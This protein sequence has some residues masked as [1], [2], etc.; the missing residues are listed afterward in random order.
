MKDIIFV[1]SDFKA[2]TNILRGKKISECL[3]NMGV[4]C[5]C[6]TSIPKNVNNSILIFIG[7]FTGRYSISLDGLQKLKSNNNKIIL[8]V[9]DKL[10]YLNLY[11]EKE[12]PY[13]Y[14]LDGIIFPN[15]FSENHFMQDLSCKSTTIYHQYDS[16]LT[17]FPI[18]KSQDF[19]VCYVGVVYQD[20]YFMN[21]PDWLNITNIEI[22]PDI[23]N[24]FKILKEYPIHFSHRSPQ[25]Q[26][27]YFK[28]S[29]KISIAAATNSVFVTSKDKTVVELLGENY[30]LYINED[31]D[32]TNKLINHLKLEFV[33]SNLDSYIE[34]L[35]PIKEKLSIN[36]ICKEYI[37]FFKQL[38]Q[39]NQ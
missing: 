10:T 15:K 39:L 28:P 11:L 20:P 32:K 21:P 23:N 4:K 19:G 18:N 13:Y 22:M 17:D 9:V 38:N 30:P 12:T 8:D 26:D 2:G 35:K 24:I 25:I 36:S 5:S 16:R 1:L 34:L 33:N 7:N 14:I 3:N 37:N 31:M 6:V 29:T 27:Y